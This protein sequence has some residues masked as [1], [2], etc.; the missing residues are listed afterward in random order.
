M[1]THPADAR[2]QNPRIQ[3]VVR[4]QWKRL[5]TKS[6]QPPHDIAQTFFGGCIY[7]DGGNHLAGKDGDNDVCELC[8]HVACKRIAEQKP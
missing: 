1:T 3:C 2:A 5:H 8:C 6:P 7:S 4:G